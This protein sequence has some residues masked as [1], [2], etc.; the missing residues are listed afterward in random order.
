MGLLTV[1]QLQVINSLVRIL[2][3][4]VEFL[5]L[6]T[7]S[8]QVDEKN[9]PLSGLLILVCEDS[10][11]VMALVKFVLERDGARVDCAEN[12]QIGYELFVQASQLGAPY[13][14]VI[15]D[16][17]MP[18]MTGYE[19]ATAIRS[20]S[21]TPVLALTAFAQ[22]EDEAKCLNAGCSGYLAK[23]IDIASFTDIVAS[24][25]RKNRAV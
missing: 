23:P 7:P 12:G 8:D 20:K 17:Q 16:M 3:V 4:C 9:E 2:L 6:V 11:T 15:T 24:F 5:R 21:D 19:L 22:E 14:I 10:D 1:Y 18:I 13:D 25:V